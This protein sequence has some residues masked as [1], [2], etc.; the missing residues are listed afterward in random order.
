MIRRLCLIL[1]MACLAL[2][3]MAAP[4]HC[5]PARA[6]AAQL[7]EHHSHHEERKAPIDQAGR[8]DC[9]GCIVPFAAA[10][11]SARPELPA[12]SRQKLHNE[13]LLARL[14]SGPDTPPPRA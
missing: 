13:L 3:A 4:L 1:L 11:G 10:G 12:S 5:A 9:I 14:T 2:P 6:S 8:H 7:A